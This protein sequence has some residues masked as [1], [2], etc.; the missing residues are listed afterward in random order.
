MDTLTRRIVADW[1][2]RDDQIVNTVR[3]F[4]SCRISRRRGLTMRSRPRLIVPCCQVVKEC[5]PHELV[6][7]DLR[8]TPSAGRERGRLVTCATVARALGAKVDLSAC[9]RARSGR[10]LAVRTSIHMPRTHQGPQPALE[11]G[12]SHCVAR[13]DSSDTQSARVAI[14][15]TTKESEGWGRAGAGVNV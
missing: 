11:R 8:E 3:T 1:T 14:S 13:C 10:T 15:E 12:S 4:D 5:H 6:A 2:C 7:Q 9:S